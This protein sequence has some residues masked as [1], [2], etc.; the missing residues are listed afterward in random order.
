MSD[1]PPAEPCT[2]RGTAA[3]VRVEGHGVAVLVERAPFEQGNAARVVLDGAVL[4]RDSAP[5][6]APGLRELTL[7]RLATLLPMGMNPANM[8]YDVTYR[9]GPRVVVDVTAGGSPGAFR[10]E[11]P[12]S[13]ACA[14]AWCDVVWTGKSK[15]VTLER[16]TQ[17]PSLLTRASLSNPTRSP[18]RNAVRDFR[19]A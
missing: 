2:F 12:G 7:E 6:S 18:R 11:L 15:T 16:T 10:G 9:G 8:A 14:K 5:V 4:Q 1:P 3:A 19:A 17:A 13:A